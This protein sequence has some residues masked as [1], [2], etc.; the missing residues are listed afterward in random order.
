MLGIRY[1][2]IMAPMFLVSNA[3][4]IIEADKAGIAGAIPALNYRTDKDFRAALEE[5]K[6]AGTKCYGINLI[7][8]KSNIRLEEQ[9]QTCVE[10]R[11]P[12]IITSLGSPKKIIDAC[13]PLGIKVF[14][15][16]VDLEYAKKVEALGADAII[17]VNNQ[18]GG[19]AGNLAP[20]ALIT[21]LR[22]NT[23]IPVIS[24]GGVGNGAQMKEMLDY[25]ACGI[26]IGS[27]FIAS[28]ECGVNDEYKKACVQY[29]AKDIVMTTRLS[30][31]PCTVINTDYVKSTGTD[32]NWL[33]KLLNKNKQ[34]KKWTKMLTFY[35]GMKLLEKAAFGATYQTMWCAGPSIEY[36]KS[37]QPVSVITGNLIKEFE[38]ALKAS[39]VT[40]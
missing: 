29:G 11:V 37:I 31:T 21:L 36:V 25:G 2:V 30:G 8:N 10:Y 28:D 23:G 3:A 17:A 6:R 16:V 9:L 35:R 27:I 18:A 7:G 5:I 22:E 34:L 15:D 32:Q 12:F 24:A 39:E 38:T 33:E 4:M 20:K 1:P 14:C 26:S 13:K 40:A 19:H